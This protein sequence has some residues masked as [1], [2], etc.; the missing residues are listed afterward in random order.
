VRDVTGRRV[1]VMAEGRQPAGRHTLVW[2][3][4]DAAGCRVPAGVYLVEL[5]ANGRRSRLKIQVLD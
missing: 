3:L 2:D 5:A 1:R 4:C